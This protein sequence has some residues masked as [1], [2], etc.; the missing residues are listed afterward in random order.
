MFI[1]QNNN[2]FYL[3]NLNIRYKW[4]VYIFFRSEDMNG[5]DIG[6]D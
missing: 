5:M 6:L 1:F 4:Y 3:V 2:L